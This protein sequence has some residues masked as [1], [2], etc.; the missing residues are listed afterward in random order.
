MKKK[1]PAQ[2]ASQTPSSSNQS[3][4]ITSRESCTICRADFLTWLHLD[5]APRTPTRSSF[6]VF[7]RADNKGSP[8]FLHLWAMDFIN[9]LC[10]SLIATSP[11]TVT[12]QERINEKSVG[13]H[14][15]VNDE[16]SSSWESKPRSFR[17][18]LSSLEWSEV[19]MKLANVFRIGHGIF[20]SF[21]PNQNKA[22]G[23]LRMSRTIRL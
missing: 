11:F 17:L 20:A 15:P 1:L 3:H 7:A 5:G 19:R 2:T 18:L 4:V 16:Y 8:M 22:S 13:P 9:E 12:D 23:S 14:F 21:S 10:P 6:L